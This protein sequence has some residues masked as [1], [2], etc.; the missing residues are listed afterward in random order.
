MSQNLMTPKGMMAL[1]YDHFDDVHQAAISH[2]V[3]DENGDHLYLALI[4]SNG[5]FKQH[6]GGASPAHKHRPEHAHTAEAAVSGDAKGT[7]PAKAMTAMPAEANANPAGSADELDVSMSRQLVSLLHQP[8]MWDAC[9]DKQHCGGAGPAHRPRH[10]HH[11]PRVPAAHANPSVEGDAAMETGNPATTVSHADV[12][13]LF[14]LMDR[15]SAYGLKEEPVT[16]G[17]DAA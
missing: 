7:T 9:T 17:G 8:V 4:R 14:K 10:S 6:Q 2:V 11:E 16:H 5:G 1:L 15:V 12:D 3:T 13:G